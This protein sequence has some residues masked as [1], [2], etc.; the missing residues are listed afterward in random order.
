MQKDVAEMIAAGANA[1]ELCV[2]HEGNRR[3]WMPVP[4]QDARKGGG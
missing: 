3:E 2:Q 4:D 1:E